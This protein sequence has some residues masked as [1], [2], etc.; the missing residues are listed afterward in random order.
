VQCEELT[1]WDFFL[2]GWI[3]VN[4]RKR[5]ISEDE[6]HIC[7]CYPFNN[8]QC[9]INNNFV[10]FRVYINKPSIKASNCSV[11]ISAN[12]WSLSFE[13]IRQFAFN[14]QFVLGHLYS[15]TRFLSL[16]L[17]LCLFPSLTT[18]SLH[19]ALIGTI[20]KNPWMVQHWLPLEK[21]LYKLYIIIL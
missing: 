16:A 5:R 2:F 3:I 19:E 10:A 21:G 7:S 20:I 4:S 11:S 6:F 17:P 9:T 13:R 15:L 14:E 18:H 12:E 1:T 8:V